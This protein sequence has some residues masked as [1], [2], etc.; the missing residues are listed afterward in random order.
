[1]RKDLLKEDEI[2]SFILRLD[3]MQKGITK[4]RK[5]HPD[6]FLKGDDAWTLMEEGKPSVERELLIDY[7]NAV[8]QMDPD[9][10]R[11]KELVLSTASE[12]YKDDP[13]TLEAIRLFYEDKEAFEKDYDKDERKMLEDEINKVIQKTKARQQYKYGARVNYFGRIK[14]SWSNFRKTETVV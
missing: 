9:T 6:R 1:M 3:T 4:A 11:K 12:I 8:I 10:W 5:D 13:K 2:Q 7:N 14:N